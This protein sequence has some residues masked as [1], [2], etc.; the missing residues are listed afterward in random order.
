MSHNGLLKRSDILL[1]FVA[2]V[3]KIELLK[4]MTKVLARMARS[5]NSSIMS[6]STG[7]LLRLLLR[8]PLLKS[9]I[10]NPMAL[11]RTAPKRLLKQIP[12]RRASLRRSSKRHKPK[13]QV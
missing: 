5:E 12:E 8:K 3:R 9:L 2:S 7:R 6:T 4:H 1:T 13:Q 10:L 11:R